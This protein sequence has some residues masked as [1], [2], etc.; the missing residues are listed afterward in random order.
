MYHQVETTKV[1]RHLRL[2]WSHLD[3]SI[4]IKCYGIETVNIGDRP[5]AAIVTI[6]MRKS[7]EVYSETNPMTAEKIIDDTYM[8]D[9]ASG[10]ND[11]EAV[12]ILK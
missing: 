10:A 11:L 12:E 2:L 9:I 8:D 4:E 7:A 6:A 1:E 5:A 3:T